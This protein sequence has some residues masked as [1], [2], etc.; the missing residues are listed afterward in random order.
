MAESLTLI[1]EP[2]NEGGFTAFVAEIPGAIS[3]GQTIDE[4]RSN[5]LD[6]L[7]ELLAYRREKA[8][9]TKSPQA[10]VTNL[11]HSA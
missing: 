8:I 3:E 2:C 6:A 5:V 11:P 1:I 9:A 4:A 10:V 7:K